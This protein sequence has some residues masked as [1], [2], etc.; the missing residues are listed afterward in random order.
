MNIKFFYLMCLLVAVASEPVEADVRL[1]S[2]F[3]DGAVLQQGVPV[4]V[5]GTAD[6]GESVTI[7]FKSQAFT[8]VADA[9]GHWQVQLAKLPTSSEPAQL[10]VAGRNT[11]VVKDVLVGEVWLCSGQSNML[12]RVNEGRDADRE[13]AAADHPLIREFR[14]QSMIADA[15]L[16]Q[17]DGCWKKCSRGT[18]GEF[19]AVGYYFARELRARLGVPVGIIKATLGGSPIEGWVSA[20]A[21]ARTSHAAEIARRWNGM[22]A[23]YNART[24]RY[25]KKLTEWDKRKEIAKTNHRRFTESPPVK[26]Y[27]DNDRNRPAGLYNGFIHPLEPYALAGF[28]WYQGEGNVARAGEYAELFQTLIRQWRADFAQGDRPFLFVQLAGYSDPKDRTGEAWAWLRSAQESALVLKNTGMAVAIDVGDSANIHPVNKQAVGARL[29]RVALRQTYGMNIDDRGPMLVSMKTEGSDLRLRFTNAAQLTL[30]GDPGGAFVVAG[31][32]H[33]F[34]AANAK[35]LGDDV[36]VSSA[37]VPVPVAVRY[38][39]NDFPHGVLRNADGLPVAPF[40]SDSW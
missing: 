25:E 30:Q 18:V 19:T 40:R 1:A 31:K 6:A 21:L 14:V 22:A 34:L 7:K 32:D 33:R 35:V 23:D 38:N 10:V 36:V 16:G 15:P 5:W 13:I 24:S 11:V 8:S 39:W 2:L 17:T 9:H 4:P 29:A 37:K 27:A 20:E 12:F 28:L 3:C 26:E